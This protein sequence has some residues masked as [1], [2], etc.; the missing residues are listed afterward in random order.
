MEARFKLRQ[1]CERMVADGGVSGLQV[2]VRTLGKERAAPRY[3]L[4]PATL[5]VAVARPPGAAL[6]VDVVLSDIQL[7]V[8]P[9]TC[10]SSSTMHIIII[11]AAVVQ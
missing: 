7:N 5:S 10:L 3:I 6:H 8:S 9:G 1:D 4:S 2:V 11:R